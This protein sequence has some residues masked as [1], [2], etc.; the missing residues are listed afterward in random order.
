M[1]ACGLPGTLSFRLSV[2]LRA[3]VA[4]GSKVTLMEHPAPATNV[5]GESGQVVV[6]AKSVTSAPLIFGLPLMVIGVPLGLA[7]VMVSGLLLTLIRSRL[8][9]SRPAAR[10][11]F[12]GNGKQPD[13]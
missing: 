6:S 11:V 13:G 9:H 12:L 2:A 10:R 1:I 5:C 3:P 4:F 8:E 7:M